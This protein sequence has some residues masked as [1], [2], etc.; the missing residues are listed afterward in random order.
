PSALFMARL[1]ATHGKGSKR[2]A[3][4]EEGGRLQP[5]IPGGGSDMQLIVLSVSLV[6]QRLACDDR[7]GLVLI[8]H[9][10]P[11]TVPTYRFQN[12][13]AH[14]SEPFSSGDLAGCASFCCTRMIPNQPE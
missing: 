3:H 2:T 1:L 12:S 14:V 7:S 5:G 9:A 10:H 13:I 6:D 11:Q 8:A 4:A